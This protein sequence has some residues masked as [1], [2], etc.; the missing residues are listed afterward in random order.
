MYRLKGLFIRP[1][2]AYIRQISWTD[3]ADL[4]ESPSLWPN[5]WQMTDVRVPHSVGLLGEIRMECLVGRWGIFPRPIPDAI[6]AAVSKSGGHCF[7]SRRMHR[8]CRNLLF[9]WLARHSIMVSRGCFIF[10]PRIYLFFFISTSRNL[11]LL[12]ISRRIL[13]LLVLCILIFCYWVLNF[14][15]IFKSF[16][17]SFAFK[18]PLHVIRTRC[19]FFL[20]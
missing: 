17:K 13:W 9:R 3:L 14:E 4:D 16:F 7:V 5:G 10:R 1:S 2:W 11:F 6:S 18:V 8:K 20:R 12:E 15:T 19:C